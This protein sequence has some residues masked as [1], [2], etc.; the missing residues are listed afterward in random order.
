MLFQKGHTLNRGRV[1]SEDHKKKL[2]A[3]MTGRVFSMEHKQKLSKAAKSRGIS[4]KTHAKIGLAKRGKY[5]GANSPNWKG[6]L[7]PKNAAIRNS[8]EYKQWR[9][10]VFERDAFRCTSCGENGYIQ[11]HH[12]KAFS[13]HPELRFNVDNGV[14][15]CPRCHEL[16][17]NFKGKAKL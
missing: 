13:T 16:T 8:L 3:A 2:A 1:V 7:T 9:Q 12:I 15:L 11:A 6:G 5:R 10:A 17:D 4:A 14:T